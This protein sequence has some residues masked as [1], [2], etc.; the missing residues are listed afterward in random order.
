MS[1]LIIIL[2]A[3]RGCP[4]AEG[5]EI[6]AFG[7]GQN[8]KG[9]TFLPNVGTMSQKLVQVNKTVHVNGLL[10]GQDFECFAVIPSPHHLDWAREIILPS[11]I[12]VLF[13]PTIAQMTHY[14]RSKQARKSMF[15]LRGMKLCCVN[16]HNF[17]AILKFDHFLNS[18]KNIANL[19]EFVNEQNVFES[20]LHFCNFRW[21]KQ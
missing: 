18:A 14:P 7:R 15:A 12:E 1:R 17:L 3:D 20:F 2:N 11:K 4:P 9:L 21:A 10:A 13:M 19:G 16:L 8:E 5:S 6:I